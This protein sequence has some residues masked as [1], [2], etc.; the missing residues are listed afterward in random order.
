MVELT[1]YTIEDFLLKNAKVPVIVMFYGANCGPCKA[2]MPNYEVAAQTH[3]NNKISKT[4]FAKL[5]N[6]ENQDTSNFCKEK[7]QVSGVPGFRSFYQGKIIVTREG[8]GNLD[9]M[10]GYIEN[11][12]YMYNI[13]KGM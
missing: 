7:W 10:E 8:G 11:T 2:T 6:W 5:H 12:I 3:T 9:T 13:L 4:K 1:M